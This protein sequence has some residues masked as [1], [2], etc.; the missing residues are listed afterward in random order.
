M[1]YKYVIFANNDVVIPNYAITAMVEALDG[2]TTVAVPLTSKKGA[3]HNPSQVVP[4][5]SSMYIAVT[6]R[7]FLYI[8]DAV[9]TCCL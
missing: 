3:G 6:L 7:Y 2:N 9:A 8:Y 1:R 4:L 5:H